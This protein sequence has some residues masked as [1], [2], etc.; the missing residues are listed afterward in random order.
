MCKAAVLL[1]GFV[2]RTSQ[3]VRQMRCIA[4]DYG[5]SYIPTFGWCRIRFRDLQVDFERRVFHL[6]FSHEFDLVQH[7]GFITYREWIWFQRPLL[8]PYLGRRLTH[9]RAVQVN[10]YVVWG[11]FMSE[12]PMWMD[13]QLF[14]G[15]REPTWILPTHNEAPP[16]VFREPPPMYHEPRPRTPER[17]R[18]IIYNQHP[19]VQ[20]IPVLTP[21]LHR[22]VVYSQHPKVQTVP[23]GPIR[24][25]DE[26]RQ[27]VQDRV[28]LIKKE[29]NKPKIVETPV[30][31]P[32]VCTPTLIWPAFVFLESTF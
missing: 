6:S 7:E 2:H 4:L 29:I 32:P 17:H 8:N 24:T 15:P 14:Y 12:T 9:Y 10:V 27:V 30:I 16:R 31:R 20:T 23:E 13:L 22:P 11:L 19:K 25:L 21:E 26:V 18:A 28:P 3:K 5:N 1:K